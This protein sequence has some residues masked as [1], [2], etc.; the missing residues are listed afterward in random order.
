M[1]VNGIKLVKI[2]VINHVIDIGEHSEQDVCDFLISEGQTEV[3]K[4]QL[5]DIIRVII[6]PRAK[7]IQTDIINK[8]AV[9]IV[10]FE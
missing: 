4:K 2:R 9:T 3:G 5:A 6:K 10:E 1:T 7:F 8:V